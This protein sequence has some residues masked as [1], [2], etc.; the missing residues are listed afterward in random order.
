MGKTL[1]ISYELALSIITFPYVIICEMLKG[2]FEHEN[3]LT[4][5]AKTSP[6]SVV[7]SE[8]Y[9]TLKR[10]NRLIRKFDHKNND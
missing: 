9:R 8:S 3:A 10:R 5:P 7:R 6:L 4:H 1:R 2:V